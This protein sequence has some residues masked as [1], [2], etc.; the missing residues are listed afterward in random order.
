MDKP[1]HI[2]RVEDV[3]AGL[4]KDLSDLR[5]GNISVSHARVSAALA[6]EYMAGIRLMMRARKSLED[7][8]VSIGAKSIEGVDQ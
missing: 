8:S 4:A 7:A 2:T 5:E 6:K 1:S 3:I